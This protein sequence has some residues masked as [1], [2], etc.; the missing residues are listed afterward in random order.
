MHVNRPS[1]DDLLLCY[2]I[3]SML[4][5]VGLAK[6]GSNLNYWLELSA[7]TAVVAALGAWS[8]LRRD[9]SGKGCHPATVSLLLLGLA[10]VAVMYLVVGVLAIRY[11]PQL[12][13][14]DDR[15]EAFSRVVERVR[16][17]PREVL[18]DPLDVVVLAER[19]I[20]LEP[21]LFSILAS[22]ERWD[23]GPLARRICAGDLGLLVTSY[24][25]ESDG[26]EYH[27]YSRWPAPVLAA[28]RS[29]MVL[30]V[31]DDGRFVYVPR[32]L[33]LGTGCEAPAS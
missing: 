21:Y 9:S 16:S 23:A 7:I 29:T 22:E 12:W 33:D 26:P 14:S 20:M 1:K 13:P 5:L 30:E 11:Y 15:M 27:G 10:F 8:A 6:V 4:P 17:E 18:A 28:L 2:W 19:P 24:P 3:A 25:L 31:R 32:D